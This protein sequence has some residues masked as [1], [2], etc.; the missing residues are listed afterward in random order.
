MHNLISFRSQ[1]SHFFHLSRA[2]TLQGLLLEQV[3]E[4]LYDT[5][6]L[7]END[8]VKMPATHQF[9]R[10]IFAL[11]V[12]NYLRVLKILLQ[13]LLGLYQV[14]D[15][16]FPEIKLLANCTFPLHEMVYNMAKGQHQHRLESFPSVI[17]SH[18]ALH[19]DL[20]M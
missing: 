10:G 8:H 9:F 18:Q 7:L 20:D 6:D 3:L 15:L 13:T 2:S 16:L 17:Q 5:Y 14:Q 12:N 1:G 11:L 4:K 19:L